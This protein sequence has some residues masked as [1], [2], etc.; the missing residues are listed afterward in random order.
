[1]KKILSTLL[2]AAMLL[3][4]VI[5]A[6]TPAAS[7][8]DGDWNV[9][10]SQHELGDDYDGVLTS[11]A[12]YEYTDDGLHIIP[13]DWSTT[14][15]YVVIQRK[16]M[17]DLKEG[18]YMEVRIDNF[19]YAGDKWFNFALWDSVGI[20]PG[21]VGYGEGVQ[22]LMRPATDTGVVNGIGTWAVEGFTQGGASA[23]FP[24]PTAGGTENVF[25]LTV[26][27]DEANSTYTF[28]ING[29]KAPQNVI[30][31][32]NTKWATDSY[33]YPTFTMQ[34]STVGGTAEA[35]VTKFGTSAEDAQ[36]PYGDDDQPANNHVIEY[37]D[38][39]DPS[40]V[41]EN[42]PAILMNG[43]Q[44]E[45][46]LRESISSSTGATITVKD[47]Y[48]VHVSARPGTSDA[49]KFYVKNET[50]HMLSD[51]PV[52]LTLTKNFCTCDADGDCYALEEMK[53]YIMAGKVI[54]AED[55][56]AT[57]LADMPYDPYV[58]ENGEGK[59][60]Y[61][62]FINDF[63]ENAPAALEDL[64]VRINGIRIDSIGVTS[65]STE[66]DIVFVAFFRNTEEAIAYVEN[67]LTDLGWEA[68]EQ[69]GNDS[70]TPVDPET[71]ESESNPAVDPETSESESDS[72]VT[73]EPETSKKPEAQETEPAQTDA[74]AEDK[75]GCGSVV[76]FGVIAVVATIAACGIVSFK[77]KK[78]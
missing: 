62:Y 5:V 10:P 54:S 49:G 25:A 50:T 73:P 55:A 78:D 34:N 45:S 53:C 30:D 31:Y 11:V 67:Y 26:T 22:T 76:G 21:R 9:F 42:A 7:A 58:I 18:V 51:F 48:S 20:A 24:E 39:I 6:A 60:N 61:L 77:K 75:G 72:D 40:T 23:S 66:F 27:W 59:D 57:S 8:I 68:P 29:A 74:P 41:E 65:T 71:S 14:A 52:A 28:D 46:D 37:G 33:A 36:V 43:N 2:V 35:T 44:A 17:V 32:M 19:T 56:Y 1:M 70:S 12:G 3:S 13:A 15:P 4:L 38:P 69:G 64:N 47:D 63:S 16:D